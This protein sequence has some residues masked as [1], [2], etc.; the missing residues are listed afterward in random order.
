MNDATVIGSAELIGVAGAL[1]AEAIGTG[2]AVA[3]EAGG[4]GAAGAVGV[5]DVAGVGATMRCWCYVIVVDVCRFD[6]QLV[7]S[8]G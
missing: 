7:W 6:M 3:N 5:K 8:L 1:V 4:V 2:S